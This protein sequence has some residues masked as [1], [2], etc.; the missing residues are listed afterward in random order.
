M[1]VL[2]GQARRVSLGQPGAHE[3][4][5][6]DAPETLLGRQPTEHD[7]TLRK[8]ERHVVEAEARYLLDEIDLAGDVAGPPRGNGHRPVVRHLEAEPLEERLLLPGRGPHAEDLVRPL[9]P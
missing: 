8:G 6:D 3:H 7:T 5:L 9:G 1:R 4:L 2:G